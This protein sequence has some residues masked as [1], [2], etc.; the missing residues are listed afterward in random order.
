[1]RAF[2]KIQGLRF[3]PDGN[4]AWELGAGLKRNT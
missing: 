2:L 1:M 4:I 3:N